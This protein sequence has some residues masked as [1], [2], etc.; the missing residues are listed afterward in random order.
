MKI[1]FFEQLTKACKK[2]GKTVTAVANE[3]KIS[4]SNVTNWKNGT[5]P[6]GDVVVRLSELLGVTAD[7]L[8]KDDAENNLIDISADEKE[9]LSYYNELDD[10]SKASVL[11]KAEGLAEAARRKKA[12]EADAKAKLK[13]KVTHFPAPDLSDDTE[14]EYEEEYID[15]PLPDIPASAGT[16]MYLD[17]AY[18]ET[19]RVKA[20]DEARKADY[21]IRVSGNSMEPRYYDG[22]ILAVC[23]QTVV[24]PGEVGVFVYDSERYVKQFGGNRLISINPDY[25]DIH[26]EDLDSFFCQ[27]KV[28][29]VLKLNN[30]N[31]HKR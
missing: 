16:G 11:G 17:N 12:L 5:T 21:A 28:I 22:D 15:L 3:L 27:G 25:K 26:I 13:T 18:A 4:K 9:L 19:I 7:Y 1:V 10:I 23:E 8:L 6:N 24:D 29:A 20:T 14:N 31:K 30:E 2:Q